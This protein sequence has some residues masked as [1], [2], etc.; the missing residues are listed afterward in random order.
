MEEVPSAES[1]YE[2]AVKALE[3]TRTLLLF[4]DVDYRLAIERFQEVIDNYPYSEYATLAELKIADVYFEQEDYLQAASYYQD[5]VELHPR[6]EM[7][8]YA[9][10]RNGICHFTEIRD[11]ER[12]QEPTH[13]AIAHFQVLIDRFPDSEYAEDARV[14]LAEARDALARHD[15]RVA[16][17]YFDRKIYHAAA[18][19][20]SEVLE[21]YPL[22]ADRD[23]TVLQLA[24]C[25]KRLGRTAEADTLLA[26]L[27]QAGT[28]GDDLVERASHELTG[29][30]P[31]YGL[32][33]LPGPC[34]EDIG[35]G[36]PSLGGDGI[37]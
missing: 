2:E 23:R 3:G 20:Y 16:Q 10:Y 15:L 17:F 37:D 25:L 27:I 34:E 4:N 7:V 19:R 33:Q 5:F 29:L 21:S 30:S 32:D 22:H 36:C 1:Y 31:S 35:P 18:R 8:P 12:D 26:Q 14:K 13:S 11:P 6:H 9:L 28:G 24:L